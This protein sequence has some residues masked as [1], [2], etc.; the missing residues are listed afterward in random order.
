[1]SDYNSIS[2]NLYDHL[3][4]IATRKSQC[5][6][7]YLNEENEFAEIRGKIVDLFAADGADWCKFSDGRII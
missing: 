3:E 2:C 4:E 6:F 7:T 1:M 5:I